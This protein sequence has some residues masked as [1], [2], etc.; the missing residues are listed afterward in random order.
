[1]RLEKGIVLPV[2]SMFGEDVASCHKHSGDQHSQTTL[3]GVAANASTLYTG[4]ISEEPQLGGPK[5]TGEAHYN[6]LLGPIDQHDFKK[7]SETSFGLTD[8]E[9]SQRCWSELIEPGRAA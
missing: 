1:M 6:F 7:I 9:S 2:T 3:S 5:L 4:G 8:L